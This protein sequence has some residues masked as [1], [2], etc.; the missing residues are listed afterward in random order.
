MLFVAVALFL[1]SRTDGFMPLLSTLVAPCFMHG[2]SGGNNSLAV[3]SGDQPSMM[4]A[5][6]PY[7]RMNEVT[8]MM[9][10]QLGLAGG[11]G[12]WG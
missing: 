1:H 9:K 6:A 12:G 10:R 2:Y 8:V 11:G 4:D 5:R 7:E 3:M